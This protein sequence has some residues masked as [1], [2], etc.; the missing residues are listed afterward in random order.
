M[1]QIPQRL[2]GRDAILQSL[3]RINGSVMYA[4]TEA[5]R[6]HQYELEEDLHLIW[7]EIVRVEADCAR[8]GKSKLRT[9]L[10]ASSEAPTQV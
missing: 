10:R 7:R 2:Q 5:N 6:Q 9:R 8:I 1:H 3:G 4:M